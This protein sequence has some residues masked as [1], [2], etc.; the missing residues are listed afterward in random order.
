MERLV[1]RLGRRVPLDLGFR[2]TYTRATIPG[3]K[4][5]K[6]NLET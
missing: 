2:S 4:T 5:G 6:K 1:T 3:S